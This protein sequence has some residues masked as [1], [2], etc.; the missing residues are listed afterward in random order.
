MVDKVTMDV[1][2][3]IIMRKRGIGYELNGMGEG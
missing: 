2:A 1:V 3:R